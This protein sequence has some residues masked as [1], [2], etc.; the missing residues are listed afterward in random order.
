MGAVEKSLRR[1]PSLQRLEHLRPAWLR[2]LLI[3]LLAA[4]ALVALLVAFFG[5]EWGAWAIVAAP[6]HGRRLPDL[7]AR[8]PDDPLLRRHGVTLELRVRVGPPDATLCAWVVDPPPREQV[9][10]Q[11]QA[12]PRASSAWPRG[13]ILLLHGVRDRKE[14]M[15]QTA[16]AYASRG[17]RCIVVDARGNGESSGAFLTY[18][19]REGEDCRQLIDEVQR[20]GLLAGRL[21]TYGCSYGAACAIQ[22]AARDPRVAAVIAVMPFSSL[23]AVIPNYAQLYVP[24]ARWLGAD[25]VRATIRRAGELAG[26]DPAAADTIAAI[27]RTRAQVLLV[28]GRDDVHIPWQHSAALHE[29]APDHSR[30]LIL[31]GWN[32]HDL[33]HDREGR[34]WTAVGDW[35]QRWVA[36]R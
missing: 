34:I 25:W 23:A 11:A 5:I 17:Y 4:G 15:L 12:A 1:W 2:W 19:I 36:V 22:H 13:T 27:R 33:A 3:A 20:R 29:A 10:E 9:A 32:H 35:L 14:S 24:F 30:L 26:F 7:P 31:D 16:H 28:H 21:A 18:G 6:N 8:P